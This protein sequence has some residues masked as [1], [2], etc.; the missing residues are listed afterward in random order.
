MTRS[1]ELNRK[2]AYLKRILTGYRSIGLAFSGGTDS[3]LLL[4]AGVEALGSRRVLAVT[5]V[6][7]IRRE[8]EIKFASSLSKRLGADHELVYT[9]EYR[10]P[11]FINEPDRRCFICKA[12]LFENL[13]MLAAENGFK[14]LVDGTNFDDSKE[15]RPTFELAER[16]GVKWPLVE[17][18]IGTSEVEYLLEQMGLNDF[19]RPH[20]SCSAW[21]IDLKRLAAG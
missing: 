19:I 11:E 12:E 16:Y 20:Y 17:A 8:A 13:K 21:E 2:L 14:C 6:S 3:T 15:A 4:R 1:K 7:P 9:K 5:A 10:N 18:E